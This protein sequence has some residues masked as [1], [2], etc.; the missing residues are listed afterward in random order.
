MVGRQR[1]L[2]KQADSVSAAVIN[3]MAMVRVH[4]FPVSGQQHPRLRR[5][6]VPLAR[7]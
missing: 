2:E 7:R 6:F 5:V 4:G 1:A 3:R